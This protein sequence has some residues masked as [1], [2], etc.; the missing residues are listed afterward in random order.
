MKNLKSYREYLEYV[1]TNEFS[2]G[3]M[4]PQVP[5]SEKSN[6]ENKS[7]IIKNDKG[8]NVPE[9]CPKCGSKIKVFFKGEPVYLCSNEK[10]KKFFGVVPCKK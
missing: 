3:N 1:C 7:K 4:L 6:S 5:L 8:Q 9:V 2:I 10:C